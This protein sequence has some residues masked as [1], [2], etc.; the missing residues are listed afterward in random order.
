MLGEPNTHPDRSPKALPSSLEIAA[1]G[2]IGT[3]HSHAGSSRTERKKLNGTEL[4][5]NVYRALG[6]DTQVFWKAVS[7]QAGLWAP[8][9]LGML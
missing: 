6:S 9:S 1:K 4:N 5:A 3:C 2:P 8:C 7:P